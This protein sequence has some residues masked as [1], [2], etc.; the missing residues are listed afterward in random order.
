[1]T[2]LYD[3]HENIIGVINPLGQRTTSIWVNDQFTALVNARGYRTTLAYTT[4]PN[5]TQAVS[6]LTNGTCVM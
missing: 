6:S 3:S 4:L 5:R 1:M 2:V